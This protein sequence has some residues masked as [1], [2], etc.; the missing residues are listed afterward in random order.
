MAAALAGPH[1]SL[2]E[3]ETQPAGQQ[4]R[5]LVVSVP[6]AAGGR[7]T[8]LYSKLIDLPAG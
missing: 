6:S 7:R 8:V 1:G 5:M 3:L 2:T 4:T